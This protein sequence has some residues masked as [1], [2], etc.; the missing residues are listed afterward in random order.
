MFLICGATIVSAFIAMARTG[1][2]LG[3]PQHFFLLGTAAAA[4]GVAVV[5]LFRGRAPSGKASLILC[6]ALGF[7]ARAPLV[8]KPAGTFD[9]THRYLWDARLQR[10]G[11]NP[12]LVLPNDPAYARYHNSATT[13]MNN[14]DVPSPYPPGAQYFFR[15]VTAFG[16]SLLVIK[17]MLVVAEALMVG[18][19]GY[20]LML[21]G[22]SLAWV[23]VYA[24]HPIAILE[25]A[26]AGHLD[27]LGVLFVV[28]AVVSLVRGWRLASALALAASISIKFLPLVLVPLLFKRVRAV[29]ALAGAALLGVL[30]V[31]FLD[32]WRVA[33]GSLGTFVDRFRFNQVLFD[34][35][36]SA[37]GA[38][39]AAMLAVAA[40][41]VTAVVLRWRSDISRPAAWAYPMAIALLFSPVIYPWYLIWLFPFL[42][43][44]MTL[45]LLVWSLAIIPTYVV[46]TSTQ[47]GAIWAVP[48]D[49]LAI[50]YGVTA[51][52]GL[53]VIWSRRR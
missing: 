51:M 13:L 3:S 25:T 8:L 34:S 30:Y 20:W 6:V 47:H 46:W 19:L 2:R 38:R 16:E 23:L 14:Q 9:D 21:Q 29:H 53:L 11:L 15:G 52:T 36:A 49:V 26:S 31:P 18:L 50:E 28:A 27:A 42:F 40:G 4:Y 43:D 17:A 48:R 12:Y 37:V 45:P 10:A 35:A 44:L 33:P 7:V 24:W 41:L 5:L 1:P 32:G 39:P 22:K